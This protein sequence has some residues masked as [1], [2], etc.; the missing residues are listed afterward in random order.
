MRPLVLIIAS[1]FIKAFSIWQ[2]L[3]NS[4]NET[5]KN[6]QDLNKV[7]KTLTNN[8]FSYRDSNILVLLNRSK[9]LT[10]GISLLRCYGRTYLEY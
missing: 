2:R 4:S 7:N 6:K 8:I 10:L 5:K 9:N 3:Q 1:V